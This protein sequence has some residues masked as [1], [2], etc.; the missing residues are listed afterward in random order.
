M[1]ETPEFA[2]DINHVSKMFHRQ[3]QRTMKEMLPAFFR[4]GKKGVVDSFWALQDID[5][6]IKKG[7]TFGVVGPNGSGKSTLLKLIARVSLPTSGDVQ[8]H[9][10]I[11]PLIEL[12]AGFHPDMTG[13]ENIF[14][15]ASILGLTKK[16]TL[17]LVESIIDF[18]EI[19][20][21]IDDPVKHYSSGMYTRLAFSVAIHVP[22]DILLV[23]EILSVGDARFR[24]KCNQQITDFKNQGKTIIYVG[25]GL[26]HVSSLCDRAAFIN[27]GH[28]EKVGDPDEV[29]QCYMDKQEQ[30]SA[31]T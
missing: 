29:I 30:E 14:L 10:R 11:T 25:H 28:L 23:D 17:P 1:S 13:R 27:Y 4:G 5:L 2:V 15:N 16:Q 31:R 24:K 8:V 20:D 6:H 7:E 9:G 19:G 18:S 26:E 22:F 3:R 21:F 12:G